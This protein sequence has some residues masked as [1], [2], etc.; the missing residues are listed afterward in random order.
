MP[1]DGSHAGFSL[2]FIDECQLSSR[3]LNKGI[4]EEAFSP[5]HRQ[6]HIKTWHFSSAQCLASYLWEWEELHLNAHQFYAR[7]ANITCFVHLKLVGL[8][9]DRN[10]GGLLSNIVIA[11]VLVSSQNTYAQAFPFSPLLGKST[12]QL[13]SCFLHSQL[14]ELHTRPFQNVDDLQLSSV[15]ECLLCTQSMNY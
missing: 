14:E 11:L 5:G 3:V 8:A 1:V 10:V 6:F 13:F 12:C 7:H 9:N 2:R 15:P 4:N